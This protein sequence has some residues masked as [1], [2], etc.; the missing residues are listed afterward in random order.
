MN[1]IV[2]HIYFIF[3]YFLFFKVIENFEMIFKLIINNKKYCNKIDINGNI[4]IYEF[5]PLFF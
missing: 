2:Y 3:I 4:R 5:F 1:E